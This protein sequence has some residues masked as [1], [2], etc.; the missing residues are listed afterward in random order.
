MDCDRH[1]N[2]RRTAASRRKEAVS[3]FTPECS[4]PG[5][6]VRSLISAHPTCGTIGDH[7]GILLD[8]RASEDAAPHQ[9]LMSAPCYFAALFSLAGGIM[10]TPLSVPFSRRSDA[11][12]DHRAAAREAGLD[13]QDEQVLW[14]TNMATRARW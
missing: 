13:M 4:S 1:A 2:Q 5:H 3:V 8:G 6:R 7:A 12:I 14:R 10:G 11:R 9:F